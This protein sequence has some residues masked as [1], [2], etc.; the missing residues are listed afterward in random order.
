[1]NSVDAQLY[2]SL[3][4][5]RQFVASIAERMHH[6]RLLAL[7]MPNQVVPGTWDK[8]K[9]GL[10]DWYADNPIE[11]IIRPGT[12]IAIEVGQ[13]FNSG[14]V[15]AGHLAAMVT[16]AKTAIVL[17][18]EGEGAHRECQQYGI[19][20]MDA[21]EHAPEGNV[22]L[23]ISLNDG[24]WLQHED[25]IDDKIQ[26]LNFDGALS[27][28]EMEAYVALRMIQRPGPGSSRLLK[29][30]V[31]EY[32]GFDVLFAERLMQLDDSRIV[33][34]RDQ[35]ETIENEQQDRWRRGTWEAGC[36]SKKSPNLPHTLHDV[37]V[38]KSAAD[39]AATRN[40]IERRYWAACVKVLTPWM[41]ERRTAVLRILKDM[42]SRQPLGS[43]GKIS[44]PVGRTGSKE[45]DPKTLE[46]NHIVGMVY[47]R[48][49]QPTTEKERQAVTVCKAVKRVRDD[50]AHLRAPASEDVLRMVR[51]MDLLLGA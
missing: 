46:Y 1:V 30:I 44:V 14:R 49:V 23:I 26:I 37:H 10:L 20:F 48:L 3:P 39:N 25:V 29:A 12:D 24:S 15:T 5:A 27:T 35:L 18:A 4:S 8:V 13:H 2:W 11:L 16:T 31:A 34:V 32:A 9:Q 33:S 40:R 7:N 51:E 36:W 22:R 42:L 38:S 50:I 41:E 45:M 28:E 47:D 19:Q 6:S 17:K 43:N 21:A